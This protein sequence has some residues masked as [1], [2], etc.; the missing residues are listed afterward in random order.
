[1]SEKNPKTEDL[2]IELRHA[3]A[4]ESSDDQSLMQNPLDNP[5]C[6]IS[7]DES[8]PCLSV[9]WKRYATSAQLRF[10][11]ENVIKMLKQ[12]GLSRILG[13]D[14]AIPVIHASDQDWIVKNWFPRAIAAGWRVSANRVPAEYFGQLTTSSVQAKVPAPVVIRSFSEL[15]EARAWLR[16][17]SPQ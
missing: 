11:L 1:M 12:H 13:D 17:Y 10:V 15:A 8:V 6:S 9:K 7:L 5:I 14:T 16:D 2:L 4:Y 3:L